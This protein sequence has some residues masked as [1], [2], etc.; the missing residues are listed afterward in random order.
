M[1]LIRS[2]QPDPAFA[3]LVTACAAH[4]ICRTVAYELAA[5]GTL[6]TFLI[7]RRRYVYIDSLH[8][9][10]QRIAQREKVAA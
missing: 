7:G 5:D 4:G 3:P 2:Q 6:D 10:P 1:E 8:T 9:L